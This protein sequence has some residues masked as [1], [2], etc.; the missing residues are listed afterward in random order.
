[1]RAWLFLLFLGALPL[2]AT[3]QTKASLPFPALT[4]PALLVGR[5]EPIP[6]KPS[7]REKAKKWLI[8]SGVTLGVGGATLATG[9]RLFNQGK[10]AKKIAVG[11]AMINIGF[12]IS[13]AT[14]LPLGVSGY[15]YKKSRQ[16]LIASAALY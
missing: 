6:H 11:D 9:V 16:S 15:W 14:L 3:A 4:P 10:N 12:G 2:F 8:V 5:L 7:P 1:M 13:F